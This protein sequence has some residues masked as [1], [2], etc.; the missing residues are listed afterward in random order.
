MIYHVPDPADPQVTLCNLWTGEVATI[1]P[2]NDP[3]E[4]ATCDDCVN[5]HYDRQ[6]ET[7][8]RMTIEAADREVW[9][10]WR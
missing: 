6:M 8:R 1:D 5:E 2:H 4:E 3:I 10:S 9:E 7:E